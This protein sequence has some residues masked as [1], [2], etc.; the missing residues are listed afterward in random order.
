MSSLGSYDDDL[1]DKLEK[2]GDAIDQDEETSFPYY[3]WA[4]AE[5]KLKKIEH[6]AEVFKNVSDHPNT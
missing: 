4:E 2:C 5:T 3:R 1:R 6:E